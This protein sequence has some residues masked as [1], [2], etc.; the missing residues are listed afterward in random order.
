MLTGNGVKFEASSCQF[1]IVGEADV[2][3]FISWSGALSRELAGDL[4][5]WLPTMIQALDPY[6]ST[7]DIRKGDR[8]LM[9]LNKEL[10]T[11][12]VGIL[13]LTPDN[14]GS[15]WLHYEAGVIVRSLDQSCVMPLL[16][17]FSAATLEGPL[18]IYLRSANRW[19]LRNQS[20]PQASLSMPR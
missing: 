2:M 17:G 8:W 13:C 10:E 4:V 9:G 19:Y 18:R 12:F 16:F 6:I 3:V 1:E 20:R 7:R 14:L 5:E 15:D 11:T